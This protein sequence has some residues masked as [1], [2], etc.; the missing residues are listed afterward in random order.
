[1]GILRISLFGNVRVTHGSWHEE[2]KLTHTIQLLLAYLTLER[3]RLHSRE[4]L[5]DLFWRDYSPERARSCLNTALWRLRKAIEPQEGNEDRYLVTSHNGEIGFNLECDCW[6]DV[7]IF[8]DLVN[9]VLKVPVDRVSQE[10]VQ[11][12]ESGL[13]LYT[14]DLLES[15]YED[16]ALAPREHKRLLYLHSL[17][18]LMHYYRL[19]NDPFKG[20]EYGERILSI[21]PLREEAH[22]ALMQ[23]YL[24]SGQRGLA[25]R[26]YETCRT[27]LSEELG[28]P[29]M[30]ETQALYDQITLGRPSAAP[31]NGELKLILHELYQAN[32]N[33]EQASRQFNQALQQLQ[34]LTGPQK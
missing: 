12:L 27:S 3:N 23:L 33:L 29:P 2:I 26:Q 21:D 22:R 16:W 10:Q 1:M 9:R 4:M 31:G 17:G 28:I 32:Q 24:E 13:D 14:A 25:V 11:E 18:Y 6:L 19:Q 7:A 20:I 5:A 30:E 15:V 34:K 8:E